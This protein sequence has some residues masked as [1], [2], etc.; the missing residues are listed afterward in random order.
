MR[1][2]IAVNFA[3][4]IKDSMENVINDLKTHTV[5]GNFTHRENLHLTVVFIGETTR[6][7]AIQQAMA[8][9]S[10]PSFTLETSSLGR[11]SRPGGDIYW[12]GLKQNKSLLAI[13]D[14]L[15]AV[16]ADAGFTIEKREYKPHLTLGREVVVNKEFNR[17]AFAK[18]IPS[19]Q[20]DVAKISLM[21]SERIGGKLVYTEIFAVPAT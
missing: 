15:C 8:K 20:I 1:L 3:P 18:T 13:Y 7:D 14:Q 19:M 11:F 9:V 16:L 10:F 4:A 12:L 21:K 2:F 17:D 6:A 5:R